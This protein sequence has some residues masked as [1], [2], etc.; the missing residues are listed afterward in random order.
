MALD[1]IWHGYDPLQFIG[2][3]P[4]QADASLPDGSRGAGLGSGQEPL[5]GAG[6]FFNHGPQRPETHPCCT[7]WLRTRGT[8]TT[9][10]LDTRGDPAADSVLSS[11]FP[12]ASHLGKTNFLPAEEGLQTGE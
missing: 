10:S 6:A 9:A 1:H 12:L 7:V 4:G 2:A 3:I 8:T 5:A 11:H